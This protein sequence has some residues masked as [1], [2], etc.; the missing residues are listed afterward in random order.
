VNDKR[1]KQ[2]VEA[3]A[4]LAV[5]DKD[6]QLSDSRKLDPMEKSI[7]RAFEL[8]SR[9]SHA[10]LTW[11]HERALVGLLKGGA[12]I[13]FEDAVQRAKAVGVP[14]KKIAFA[15]VASFLYQGDTAGA[16]SMV[17][18]WDPTSQ[19]DAWF[20]LL[21]GA[22]FER[23]GDA[24]AIERFAAAV[25]LDP[26]LVIAQILLSRALAVE[27]DYR[28]AH[29]L[30]K[31]LRGRFPDRQEPAALIVL[32]WT[33]DPL[34]GEQPAEMKDLIEKSE[35]LPVSLRSVPHAARAILSLHKG[36]VDEARPS[37]QKGLDVADTPGIAAWLGSIAHVMGDETLARKAALS[38]VASVPPP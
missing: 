33:R 10:S 16:A 26:D 3:E 25:K 34:R 23:A 11:L 38:A 4:L 14:E 1:A 36:A 8:E 7:S 31:E 18:K 5:V 30:A 37:L 35:G 24:R 28:R 22:T 21:A 2:H 20:N 12:D 13:A 15:H 9:S 17:A 32:A 27:G 29:D 6:L 19:D